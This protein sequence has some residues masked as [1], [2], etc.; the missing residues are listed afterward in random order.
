[1]S[2]V[3]AVVELGKDKTE[4]RLEC[5]EAGADDAGVELN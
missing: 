4:N 3:F 1:M 2:T 5:Y